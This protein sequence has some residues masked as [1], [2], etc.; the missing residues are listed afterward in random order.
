MSGR[1]VAAAAAA[2]AALFT[3]VAMTMEVHELLA[4][5]HLV[6]Q[7]HTDNGRSFVAYRV[8]QLCPLT[9]SASYLQLDGKYVE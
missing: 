9:N 8:D 5:L 7:Y 4:Q 1:P 3:V 2:A 6:V